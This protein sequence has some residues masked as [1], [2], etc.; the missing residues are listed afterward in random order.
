MF[1]IFKNY[2][3]MFFTKRGI[4]DK[5]DK[6]FLSILTLYKLDQNTKTRV[7]TLEVNIELNCELVGKHSTLTHKIMIDKIHFPLEHPD[8]ILQASTFDL[9]KVKFVP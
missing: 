4:N 8:S 9:Y 7:K 2:I 1:N 3:P 6:T 5:N